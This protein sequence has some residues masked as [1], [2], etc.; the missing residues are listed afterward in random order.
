M[1]C[2]VHD[3]HNPVKVS[4]LLGSADISCVMIFQWFCPESHK[5][6]FFLH[7]NGAVHKLPINKVLLYVYTPEIATVVLNEVLHKPIYPSSCHSKLAYMETILA[8]LLLKAN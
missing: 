1:T 7:T 3:W 4:S 6:G 8:R 5:C 2:K